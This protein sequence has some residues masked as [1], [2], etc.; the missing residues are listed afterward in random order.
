M[1]QA[2]PDLLRLLNQLRLPVLVYSTRLDAAIR[3]QFESATLHFAD[4]PLD[5]AAVGRQCDLA[6]LNASHG[7]TV[8]MLLAG[9]PIL[10][11]PLQLEQTLTATATDRLGVGL[12]ADPAKPVQIAR[13][14]TALLTSDR[15]AA[16][17]KRFADRYRFRRRAADRPNRSPCQGTP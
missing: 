14:L 12:S 6:I 15:F 4:R 10:Q 5:L 9:K 11:I 1:F 8:S 2:L 16:G 13:T 3:R 7:A 17:A